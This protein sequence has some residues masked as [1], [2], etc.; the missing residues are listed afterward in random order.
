MSCTVTTQYEQT[1]T[2]TIKQLLCSESIENTVGECGYNIY[3]HF[4]PHEFDKLCNKV[5]CL[6]MKKMQDNLQNPPEV[7]SPQIAAAIEKTARNLIQQELK[8]KCKIVDPK[9]VRNPPPS[10]NL[11]KWVTSWWQ[12]SN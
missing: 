2:M 10:N 1:V 7:L 4:F 8:E 12:T 5:T 9:T 6:A 3:A 11:W